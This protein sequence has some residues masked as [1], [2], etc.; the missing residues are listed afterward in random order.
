MERTGWIR[1]VNR[2]VSVLGIVMAMLLIV[3]SSKFSSAETQSNAPEITE[4]NAEE[5]ASGGEYEPVEYPYIEAGTEQSRLLQRATD[6][7]N[8]S[9][10]VSDFLTLDSENFEQKYD[11]DE[12]YEKDILY[13]DQNAWKYD[14][15]AVDPYQESGEYYDVTS[16]TAIRFIKNLYTPEYSDEQTS[17]RE[18]SIKCFDDYA[19]S[20][21]YQKKSDIQSGEEV[22][23]LMEI[24]YIK[25]EI[26]G[27]KAPKSFY[28][29]LEN[30]YYQV[31]AEIQSEKW[32]ASPD[33]TK[34]ACVSNGALPKHPSQIFVRYQD[35]IPDSIFRMPWECGIAGWIDDDHIVCYEIDMSGPLL[36]HLETNQIEEV[37]KEDDNYDIY[38]A[39]YEVQDNQLVCTCMGEEIYRWG[40][41]RKNNDITIEEEEDIP[42]PNPYFYNQNHIILKA[43]YYEDWG[44]LSNNAV[45]M[46]V[47][48]VKSYEQGNVYKFTI[49]VEPDFQ[50]YFSG[51]NMNIYFY[52]TE[53]KIYRLRP[54]VQPQPNGETYYFYDDDELLIQMLDTDEKVMNNGEIVCQEEET[55]KEYSSIKVNGD[56]ITYSLHEI[57]V[58][59]EDG[60][61][62]IFVWEKGKGL[63][64]Y[65]AGFGSQPYAVYLGEIR[66]EK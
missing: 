62:E 1:Y 19:I 42:F 17:D 63:I 35:K 2:I 59:G 25:A 11:R 24:S 51:E 60:Y 54:Y 65:K 56:Q 66:I 18:I 14:G 26:R 29:E 33:G 6:S 38:G 30:S 7:L 10:I 13:C 55:G 48:F 20:T 12:L 57:K 23:N 47:S 44:N 43:E 27:E 64:E 15:N 9:T 16:V 34:E 58:N 41:T 61:K 52:V 46:Q 53:D 32:I 4:N 22:L 40:I 36:I 8:T 31:R 50:S 3:C 45:D 21:F 5:E 28:Q 39:K 49:D 37:K